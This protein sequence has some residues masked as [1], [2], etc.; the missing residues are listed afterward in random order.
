[1]MWKLG[2]LE[3]SFWYVSSIYFS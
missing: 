1:M 2:M 3:L